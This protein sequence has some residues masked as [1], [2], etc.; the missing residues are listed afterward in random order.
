LAAADR[1]IYLDHNATTPLLPEVLEAM[2]PFLAEHHGNPSSSHAYGKRARLAVDAARE[3]VA[4]LIGGLPDEVV[5]TSGGTEANNLAILG[6]AIASPRRRLVTSA[7]EHPATAQPCAYLQ[8]WGRTLEVLPVDGDGV[9]SLDPEPAGED[10]V[11]LTV[12]LAQNETGTLQPVPRLSDW[13]HERGAL[14]HTDAAQAVGKVPVRVDRLGVD[15]LSIAGHKLYAPKGVGALY[16]RRGV[17]LEPVLRGA[18]QERGRRPGT[19]NVASI[20]G[21]GAAAAIAGRDLEAEARR[22]GGLRDDLWQRLRAAIPGMRRNGHPGEVLPNTLNVSFPGVA[23]SAV[24][25]AA[26]EI[27]AVTGSA[28]HEGDPAP[29]PVLTAMGLDAATSLGAVRLSL[30]RGTTPEQVT[31]AAVALIGAYR[32]LAAAVG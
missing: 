16:V 2:L 21:L 20:V 29:S 31:G 18:G 9:I 17:R 27:A 7:V 14:V 24:L 30:G 1:P 25:D 22:Q 6:V 23:G 28:C 4:E 3:Q 8:R 19:E 32:Q 5:F 13:A 10:P 15:L 26:P 12:I 11:L